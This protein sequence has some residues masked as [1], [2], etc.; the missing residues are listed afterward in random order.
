VATSEVGRSG[1]GISGH[2]GHWVLAMVRLGLSSQEVSALKNG[3]VGPFICERCGGE[4]LMV[5]TLREPPHFTI[6]YCVGKKTCGVD[7]VEIERM[8]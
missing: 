1:V 7:L 4:S 6:A 3:P 8:G 5:S 2:G